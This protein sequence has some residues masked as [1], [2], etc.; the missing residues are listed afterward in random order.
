MDWQPTWGISGDLRHSALGLLVDVNPFWAWIIS[1]DLRHLEFG[2]S[3]RC[4]NPFWAWIISGDLRHSALGLSRRLSTHWCV[5]GDSRHSAL[6]LIL[7]LWSYSYKVKHESSCLFLLDMK[8][9]IFHM[10]SRINES[11]RDRNTTNRGVIL[12]PV[13]RCYYLL[14]SLN[15]IGT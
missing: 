12:P 5:L 9:I 8:D 13:R 6:G 1:G 4:G 10:Y 15:L 2:L 3:C 11:H 7:F 14:V